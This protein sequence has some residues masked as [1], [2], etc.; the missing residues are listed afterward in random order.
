MTSIKPQTPQHYQSIT[1]IREDH[2]VNKTRNLVKY[3]EERIIQPQNAIIGMN[4]NTEIENTHEAVAAL[5][6]NEE[7]DPNFYADSGATTHMTNKGGNFLNL[8]PYFGTD[9]VFVGNGQALPITHTGKALLKTT[10]GKLHLN[11]V[12]V[13]PKLKKKLLY[14]SQLINDNSCT[15]EFNNNGFV[16]KN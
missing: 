10:Q 12:L 6:V 7:S 15:F 14:V 8:K 13:V 11:N 2:Q 3:V 16:I 5:T 4:I 9:T 1:I